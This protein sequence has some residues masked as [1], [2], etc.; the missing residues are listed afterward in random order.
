MEREEGGSLAGGGD[1]RR[2][3]S[4]CGRRQTKLNVSVGPALGTNSGT[5]LEPEGGYRE[6]RPGLVGQA[7]G[8]ETQ[9]LRVGR[10][11]VVS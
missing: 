3:E 1:R 10:T 6:V 5:E 8:F 11:K 9:D 2:G 4:S 7:L